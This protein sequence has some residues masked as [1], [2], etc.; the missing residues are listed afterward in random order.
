MYFKKVNND[1][2]S[3]KGLT[4]TIKKTKLNV[5]LISQA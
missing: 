5:K 1:M 2:I 3:K 4:D